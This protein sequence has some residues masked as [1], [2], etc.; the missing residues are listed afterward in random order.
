MEAVES[1]LGV[2]GSAS[3]VET[4]LASAG[5]TGVS[6]LDTPEVSQDIE[7]S[8]GNSGGLVV[9]II[10]GVLGGLLLIGLLV[11]LGARSRA[12]DPIRKPVLNVQ[13]SVNESRPPTAR[14]S[15]QATSQVHT[16]LAESK[17]KGMYAAAI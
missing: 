11:W 8:G 3:A 5:I 13:S 1:Q 14:P 10:C 17:G 9:G 7:P 12:A 4:M 15:M 2:L 16:E 6:V